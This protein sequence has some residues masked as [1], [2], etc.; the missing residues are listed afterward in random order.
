MALLISGLQLEHHCAR[1][2]TLLPA[3]TFTLCTHSHA[4]LELVVWSGSV[5]NRYI[6]EVTKSTDVDKTPGDILAA[7]MENRLS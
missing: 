6:E 2:A 4:D 3:L 5:G 1:L 7:L